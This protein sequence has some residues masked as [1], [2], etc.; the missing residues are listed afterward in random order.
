MEGDIVHL[1]WSWARFSKSYLPG[2]YEL[3]GRVLS[4]IEISQAI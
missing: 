3:M 1:T 4:L 2:P